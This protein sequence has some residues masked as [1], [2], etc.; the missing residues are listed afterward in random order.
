MTGLVLYL[1]TVLIWG[2]TWIAITFQL[3][4]VDATVSIAHRFM[5]A[6]AH[7]AR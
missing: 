4:T 6:A 1:A 7:R 2:S 5:L 3:G